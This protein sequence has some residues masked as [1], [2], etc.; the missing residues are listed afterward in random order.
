[1]TEPE[2]AAAWA[3]RQRYPAGRPRPSAR[4]RFKLDVLPTTLALI[5]LIS[6]GFYRHRQNPEPI[7]GNAVAADTIDYQGQQFKMSRPY[8]E[9]DDYKD[10]PNN[11]NTNE[12]PR[13]EQAMEAVKI[14]ASFKDRKAFIDF[15]I[16]DLEFPGYGSG[17]LGASSKTDD[18]STIETAM[19]EIP[20]RDEERVAVVR[21]EA[22][23]ELKLVDDFIYSGS[24]T[25]D[26]TRV[27]LDR[28]QLEY[29]DRWESLVRKKALEQ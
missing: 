3:E 6:L 19:V 23:A 16:G 17:F 26:I 14:P 12:L 9:Y 18:G 8:A 2:A 29:F 27:R 4:R 15:M 5:L 28:G 10:D 25:N 13:I 24:D 21:K 1:M 7:G 22:G 20:Q 11:L